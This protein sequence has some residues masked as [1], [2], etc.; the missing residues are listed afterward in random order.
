M[1][2]VPARYVVGHSAPAGLDGH[3]AVVVVDREL[4]GPVSG[5]HGAQR[6]DTLTASPWRSSSRASSGGRSTVRSGGGSPAEV[7][8]GL[9]SMTVIVSGAVAALPFVI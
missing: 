4:G 5:N 3:A 8:C 1:I 9:A 2:A 7:R 6:H